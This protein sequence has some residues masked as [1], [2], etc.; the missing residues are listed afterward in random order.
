MCGCQYHWIL[1]ILEWMCLP[2]VQNIPS[3]LKKLNAGS[4]LQYKARR[5]MLLKQVRSFIG[6]S[7]KSLN[8]KAGNCL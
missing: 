8:I 5:P 4:F 3:I 7:V 1:D 6:E 2:L